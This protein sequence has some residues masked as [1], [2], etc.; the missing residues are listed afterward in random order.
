MHRTKKTLAAVSAALAIAGGTL[1]LTGTARAATPLSVTLSASGAGASAVWDSAGNPVLI[2]GLSG[3]SAQVKVNNAP[4]S[5][6][7]DA[8]TFTTTSYSGGSPRWE[9]AFADGATLHGLPSN[10]DLGSS[11]WQVTAASGVCT[12]AF[13]GN[14]TYSAAVAFVQNNGCG[15]NVT[16]ARIVAD[17]AGQTV[18]STDHI[19]SI[20]YASMTLAAGAD[21]VTVTNPGTLTGTVGTAAS[22]QITAS[23]NKGDAI[24]SYAASGLP[25][26]L[27]IDGAKGLISGTP[28][29]AGNFTVQVTVTDNGGT[30]GTMS[31]AWNISSSQ[32]GP[33]TTYFGTMRLYK[34][35]L[36]LD[37]KF[38]IVAPGAV[39]WVW[40]CNGTGAQTW[41]VMSDGTIRHAGLCLGAVGAGTASRTKVDL[42][43]CNGGAGQ[44]WD[45]RHWRVNYDNPGAVNQVLDDTAFGGWGTPLEIFTSNGGANQSWQTF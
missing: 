37:D 9:I 43:T 2:V 10:A 17:G 19:A 16:G 40:G 27:T 28:T 34:M 25:T 18:G 15:G 36:C 32:P 3:S 23:S 38:S 12:N 21:V 1:A 26:G 13:P 4:T 30:K 8:P 44:R 39:V 42:Q 20:S 14:V 22:G 41:S 33:V 45:T 24:A 7:T 6:P 5:A 35:H 31:F 29:T 11:N